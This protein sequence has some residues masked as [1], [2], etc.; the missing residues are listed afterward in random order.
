[1]AEHADCGSRPG[2]RSTSAIRT[3]RGSA[4]RTR[5][6]TDCCASTSRKAPIS[7]RMAPTNSP[8]SQHALNARPRKTLGWKTP[9]EALDELLRSVSKDPCCDDRLNPP[10]T[11]RSSTPSA[12]PRPVIE[13]SVGSV[14]DSYDNA[15]AETINGLYK[16]EVIHRRGPWRS[17]KPSSSRRSNGSTGSTIAGCWSRSAT[18]RRPKPRSDYYASPGATSHWRRNS[19]ETASGKPG[20]G[21]GLVAAASVGTEGASTTY[22]NTARQRLPEW[23]P[24]P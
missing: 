19:N 3:A 9:A 6:P 22:N 23:M 4:A 5:T 12:W 21:T 18:S 13:P 20:A 8:P 17:S 10:S 7:P 24:I 11:S 15:L 14:G 2:C 1:M 16:A